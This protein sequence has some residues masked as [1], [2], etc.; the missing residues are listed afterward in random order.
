MIDS[1]LSWICFI[2]LTDAY[3]VDLNLYPVLSPF[4][5]SPYSLYLSFTSFLIYLTLSPFISSFPILFYLSFSYFFSFSLFYH[6]LSRSYSL[7]PLS[8][9]YMRLVI[10]VALMKMSLWRCWTYHILVYHCHLGRRRRK[11]GKTLRK[12]CHWFM[13]KKN[14]SWSTS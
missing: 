2:Q 8:S 14:C 3:S 6:T 7:S 5:L 11:R 1:V 13:H 4:S 12:R 10:L 9:L